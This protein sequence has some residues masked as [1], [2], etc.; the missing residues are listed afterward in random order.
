[1]TGER[2]LR[3]VGPFDTDRQAGD[4]SPGFAG[5]SRASEGPAGRPCWP[6]ETCADLGRRLLEAE[7]VGFEPTRTGLPP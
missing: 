3:E 7:G 4:A 6:W 1:M 5:H 2:L